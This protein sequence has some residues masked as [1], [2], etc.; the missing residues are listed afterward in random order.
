[1]SYAGV[2][3]YGDNGDLGRVTVTNE[4]T[5]DTW[6]AFEVTGFLDEGFRIRELGSGDTIEYRRAVPAGQLI[7]LNPRT[8]SVLIDGASDGTAY[9]SRDEWTSLRPGQEAVFQFEAIGTGDG[10]QMTVTV[11]DGFW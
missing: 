4:G 2:L 11:R 10:A 1:M 8:G 9:L 6:P 7:A 5:A 3:S